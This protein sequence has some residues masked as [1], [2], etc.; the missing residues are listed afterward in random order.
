MRITAL[1]FVLAL[2]ACH[3]GPDKLVIEKLVVNVPS[4]T[5]YGEARSGVT[6]LLKTDKSVRVDAGKE[7]YFARVDVAAPMRERARAH[8]PDDEDDGMDE[9]LPSQRVRVQLIPG[10]SSEKGSES[11]RTYDSIGTARITEIPAHDAL[12]A[13]KDAWTVI[14]TMRLLDVAEERDIISALAN[15]DERVQLFAVQRLG[16]RRSKAAVEPLIGL[17]NQKTRP[18]LALR[19]IGAL[20]A[21]GDPRAA[22]PMI[23]LAHNQDPQF[24]L[25]VV[26][27]L[28]ALGG[29]TAEG[30]LVTLASGHPVEAVRRGAEDALAELSRKNSRK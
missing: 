5:E 25:Q 2:S 9:Q 27:A 4:D 24:V 6:E 28:A 11:K 16:E 10:S 18:E 8:R 12:E 3:S 19:A 23:E 30:Y 13:F 7:G 15:S 20:I 14:T 22:E 1:A 29:P 17:L 21:I 26:F